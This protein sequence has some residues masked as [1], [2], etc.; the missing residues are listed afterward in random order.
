MKFKRIL[1]ILLKRSHCM[2]A[3]ELRH[4]GAHIGDNFSNYGNIDQGHTHLLTIGNNVTLAS[5]CQIL[6]H[7]A[8]TK[9]VLGYSKIGCITIGNNV[10][11][12]ANAIILPNTKIGSN[13]IIGAGSV[14]ATDIPDNSVVVGNP[15]KIIGKYDEYVK[16]N[17]SLQK[18][19]PTYNK[20][21]KT[22]NDNDRYKQYKD[23][24]NGGI[25]FD[26]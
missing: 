15:C 11:V 20:Y 7:D 4:K 23:L 18:N 13:C 22:M 25:G 17:K 9:A 26:L 3:D 2:T 8:S 19:S 10:F 24:K 6:T 16:K 5:G 1:D 12:G 14:I 21:W